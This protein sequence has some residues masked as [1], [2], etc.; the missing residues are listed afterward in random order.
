MYGVKLAVLI[1]QERTR[2]IEAEGLTV[3]SQ[4][5]QER[6][7]RDVVVGVGLILPQELLPG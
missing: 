1:R 5:R 3:A 6:M 4:G 2:T 7:R